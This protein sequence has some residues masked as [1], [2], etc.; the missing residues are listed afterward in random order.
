MLYIKITKTYPLDADGLWD[1]AKDEVPA[2]T[3]RGCGCCSDDE[4]ATVENVTKAIADAEQFISDLRS[5][6][7]TLKS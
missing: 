3:T 4:I 5:L 7:S 6:L 2:L 1:L